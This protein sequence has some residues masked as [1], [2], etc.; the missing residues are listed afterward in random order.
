MFLE[1]LEVYSP[2]IGEIR[3]I[4]FH[5]GVNLIL[6]KSTVKKSETGNS[7]GKTTALR[8]IDFC[9]GAKQDS[10]Y[11]DPEFKTEDTEIKDFLIKNEVEFKITLYSL[12]KRKLIIKRK[13]SSDSKIY[14]T[15]NDDSFTTLT[16]FHDALKLNLFLS[17]SVKPSF[18][19]IMTR[20]IRTSTE[21]MSN[22]LK[23]V[24]MASNSDY[25]T[26][27][28]FLFGFDDA[29]I[30]SAK[31]KIGKELK[32][33]EKELDFIAKIRSKNS[34]EQSLSVIERDINEQEKNIDNYNLG[35]SYESQMNELN[36]IKTEVSQLSLELSSLEMKRSLNNKAIEDLLKQQD[37]TNPDE[38]KKLYDEATDR[39]GQLNKT[40]E[41][42]L[43][44]HNQMIIKKVEFIKSQMYSLLSKIEYS[45][46][47]LRSWL[48]K[49]S[50]ILRDLARLGSLSDLQII[51]KEINKLY[52][53]K[54]SF[55]SSLDQIKEYEEKIVSTKLRLDDVSSKINAQLDKF[56]NKLAIF[57]KYFS[58]Y[59]KLL[60]EEEY[61]LSYDENKGTYVFTIEPLG[62]VK[63]RGNQGDGKKK[64]Q[65]SALDLAYLSTQEELQSKTMRFVAHDGIEAIHANQ[66]K[67]LFDIASSINGQYI[68]AILK[69]KLSSVDDIF[70]EKNQVLELSQDDKFFKI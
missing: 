55:E 64:A 53:R 38:L 31:Q 43:N 28:L 21:K 15:I 19:Q 62:T 12:N 30:L 52:E 11:I 8:S 32:K 44:F 13:I 18:R 37:S 5:N 24:P 7:V 70:I 68:L 3:N 10:F 1:K 41:D 23:T 40:F 69:D 39:V 36:I 45:K 59:T 6:D 60:Y 27:N 54:G 51:Q 16:S 57:N 2:L 35:D 9:L 4:T 58:E 42:A 22:A 25:E 56:N 26:L 29:S 34:L 50:S 46:N 48:D 65:V 49:E 61:I 17:S 14:C 33:L 63:T 47:A 20:F 67:I 66:I